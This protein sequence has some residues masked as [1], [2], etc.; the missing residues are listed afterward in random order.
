MNKQV[1]IAVS[2]VA[3]FLMVLFLNTYFNVSSGQTYNPDGEGL[4]RYY[5]SGPDPYYNMRIVEQTMYGD[6]PG[7]YPFFT[8]EDPLLNYPL[9]RS[10]GRKPLMNM[11]AIMIS[12]FA[13]PFIDEIDALGLAM[14]FLPAL[15]GA[16]LVFPVYFLGKELFNRKTGLLAAF[17]L[18]LIPVHLGSGH[19]SAFALFDHDSFNLFMII[20][21][22]LFLIKSLRESDTIKSIIYAALGGITLAG[23]Q[24]VWVEAEFLFTVIAA[25][26]IVQMI[27]D[28]FTNKVSIQVPRTVTI[29]MFTGYFLSLP[30]ILSD[31]VQTR[32]N[33][34]N[35]E[36]FLCLVVA[37]FGVLYIIFDKKKIPWTL[38]I[39]IVF[40]IGA[41]GLTFLYF[42]PILAESFPFLAGLEKMSSILYGSGIYG[43]KVA[44]TIA[45]AGT[46]GMSRT[47]MSFG[48]ALFWMSWI[49]FLLVGFYYIRNE[50]RKDHFFLLFLFLIQIWFIFVAGRFIN[51]LVVP[52]ALL[53]AWT[54]WFMIDKIDYESMVRSIKAAGGGIHGLRRGVK[55]LHV[56]GI[57][58]IAL[59]I[60][61]PNAYLSLDAAVPAGEKSEV[62]G[63]LPSG[64]F[65]GGIGKETYWIHA[66]EWLAQQDT[67]ISIAKD[68]PA[69]I[70]WWDYG[71]YGSAIAAHPMVADNFQDGIPPAA[72]FHTSTSE[73]EAVS[74]W[75]VRLLE[76]NVNDY[77]SIQSSVINVFDT[78]IDENDTQDIIHWI[79][80]PIKSP[81][82][83]TRV[84]EPLT[85]EVETEY[86]IGQQWPVNA[87]YHDIV[88]L[89]ASYD[90]ETITKL[91]RDLQEQTGYSI[92]YYGV[93]TYD[94]QIFNI[95]AYLAD[96]S[97][98]LVSGLGDYA[99]EDDFVEITYQT[100]SGQALTYYEVT[101]RTDIENQQ[102]P[103]VDTK[104][105][106][107]DPYFE[108]MFYRTYI[109]V[110]QTNQDGSKSE[111]NYQIPCINMKHFYA[112]YISPYPEYAVAQG[113]S[114][115]VIAKY[116]ECAEING[117]IS[118]DGVNKD[119]LVVVQQNITHY[120]TQ[121]PVDHD[122]N[123]AINGSYMV[124]VPAGVSTLQVRRYPELGVNAFIVQNVTLNSSDS[125]SVLAPITEEEATRYGNYQRTI[126]INISSSVLSGTVY[127]DIDGIE[128]YNKT[129]D[130]PLSNV[131]IQIF[132]INSFD[133]S[134]GQPAAYDFSMTETLVTDEEGYYNTSELL[135]GYYQIVALNAEGFQIE[136]TII[137]LLIGNNTHDIAQPKPGDVEGYIFFDENDNDIYDTGEELNN[138]NVDLVYRITGEEKVVK[139]LITDFD[140]FY[141]FTS[142]IPGN[143][144]LQMEKL[145]DYKSTVDVAITENE[146]TQFNASI[147]Y[148]TIR[149]TGSTIDT[150]TSDNI[151][152]ISINFTPDETIENNTAV[153]GAIVSDEFGEFTVDL[154]PGTYNVG[155]SQTI[156]E[157]NINVTYSFDQTLT[158]TIGQGSR[159]Y[160]IFLIRKEE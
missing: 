83:G 3:I 138:V 140:G 124:L 44:D 61:L 106:Y 6:N 101:E 26:A 56:F 136:N 126:D 33:P 9:E 85:E 23:L 69:Y 135:P 18:V 5:L 47:V 40:V 116:Y 86:P 38:S 14:Q 80:N 141:R 39:P 129:S 58:F 28:M 120:G 137:P 147:Q 121:I 98:L 109:G 48:P 158:L 22:Y 151:G 103:L 153:E 35:L 45:E 100:Q 119:F 155:V 91:Y 73:K 113:K 12:Q 72:N 7:E 29:L 87:A 60:L 142:L 143:Y 32:A 42:I 108:S 125:I 20:T 37:V 62:F 64:A 24:M 68:R 160:D 94:K 117:T 15:F 139:S 127:D 75:I 25:Y 122:S 77:G 81:S 52:V 134:T 111:P 54:V 144:Q 70:S 55:F 92:R 102:D 99:P 154:Q 156:P 89:L 90:E 53:G 148:A 146:T 59:L 19:G 74:V 149:V 76:G 95:F 67:E 51:D 57:L 71:F 132:G 41:G 123:S 49:G 114:A 8:E 17:F 152:E 36:L 10:G 79:E 159:T 110:N 30:V 104:T 112:Q 84:A 130:T 150:N 97:L 46:Y 4:G 105:I 65:G 11:M 21:T 133:P 50:L 88:E 115:V 157:D 1:W 27:I 31:V 128:G 93:E 63:D 107:K 78:Y 16:L 118:F 145:P 82:Y 2:L 34:F 131:D 43:K 96:K 66:Y 13:T